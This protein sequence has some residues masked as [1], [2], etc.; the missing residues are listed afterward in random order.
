[1]SLHIASSY[2]VSSSPQLVRYAFRVRPLLTRLKTDKD[3]TQKLVAEKRR[4]EK[5]RE[6]EQKVKWRLKG[7]V[8]SF[9]PTK[10]TKLALVLHRSERKLGQTTCVSPRNV[11][12]DGET[13]EIRE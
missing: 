9:L 3:T 6:Q 11:L 1:M 4:K 12:L 7:A 10:Y 2:L 13:K 8:R 5:R